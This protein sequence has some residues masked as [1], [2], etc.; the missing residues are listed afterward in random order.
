VF[1]LI[2]HLFVQQ[3]VK[4][5]RRSRRRTMPPNDSSAVSALLEL[6]DDALPAVYGYLVRRCDSTA[7]AEDLTGD[8]FVAAVT[9]V[10][11]GGDVNIP[12]LIGTARHKLVDHWR[13][14]GRQRDLLEE[15]WEHTDPLDDHD[16]P[17]DVLHVRDTLSRLTPHHRAA[18]VLRYMDGLSVP[19][20]ASL[21]ERSVHA[22]E[23]LLVRAKAAYRAT[24]A[25]A[26]PEGGHP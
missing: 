1:E 13:R 21:L 26:L 22:T 14:L 16:D 4:N 8:T 17:V 5:M 15:L 7:T 10:E 2:E 23:S 25:E 18:L 19:E 12:W 3:G 24:A 20:V 11:R 9:A 6:Y